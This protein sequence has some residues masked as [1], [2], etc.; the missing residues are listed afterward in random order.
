M[1]EKKPKTKKQK[2]KPSV[3]ENPGEGEND[4]EISHGAPSD[5]KAAAVPG[6]EER[7]G[8]ERDEVQSAEAPPTIHWQDD[9]AP[10]SPNDA[11][12]NVPSGGEGVPY[13]MGPVQG[14]GPE[15]GDLRNVVEHLR[16]EAKTKDEQIAKLQKV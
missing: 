11:L 15:D 2:Q 6:E 12:K 1:Q 5:F 13:E 16:S 9:A 14:D 10:L 3:H 8:E 7:D 4:A